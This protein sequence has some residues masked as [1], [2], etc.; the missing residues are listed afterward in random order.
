[1]LPKAERA[2]ARLEMSGA[3]PNGRVAGARSI[4]LDAGIATCR[5]GVG[6][7]PGCEEIAAPALPRGAIWDAVGTD[8]QPRGVVGEAALPAVREGLLFEPKRCYLP[9]RIPARC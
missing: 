2:I 6:N 3:S 4:A 8:R 1:M 9:R 7:G 5:A